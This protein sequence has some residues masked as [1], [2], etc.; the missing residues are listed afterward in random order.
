VHCRCHVGDIPGFAE[1]LN[2]SSWWLIRVLESSSARIATVPAGRYTFKSD[3]DN[4][5]MLLLTGA[6]A[7]VFF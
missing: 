2:T 3:E 5:E 7:A 1:A 4:P 6:D